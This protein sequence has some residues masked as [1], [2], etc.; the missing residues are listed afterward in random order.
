MGADQ[1]KETDSFAAHLARHAA[2]CER[3]GK[4]GS[5]GAEAA[6]AAIGRTDVVPGDVLAFTYSSHEAAVAFAA[7]NQENYGIESLGVA[8]TEDGVIGVTYVPVRYA[9][10]NGDHLPAVPQQ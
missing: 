10:G 5:Y 7:S 4:P 9:W 3:W 8:E 6:L 2:L 1:V